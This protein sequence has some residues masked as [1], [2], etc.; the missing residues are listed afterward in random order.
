METVNHPDHYNA[1]GVEVID[2]IE[3]WGLDFETGNA[4]KYMCR[5]GRKNDNGIED[6]KKALW[7]IRREANRKPVRAYG[8][9][10]GKTVSE[11][12]ARSEV[13][14]DAII[15]LNR[16]S[17]AYD[18]SDLRRVEVLLDGIINNGVKGE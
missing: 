13:L 1:N 12:F 9:Y 4:L 11:A 6:L 7:Y 18:P 17:I 16:Y 15:A 10:D 5:A 14:T 2:V 3:N 8:V